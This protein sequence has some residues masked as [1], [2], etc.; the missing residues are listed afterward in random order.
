MVIEQ[1]ILELIESSGGN[2]KY[3]ATGKPYFE[4]DD[5]VFLSLNEFAEYY[6]LNYYVFLRKLNKNISLQEIIAKAKNVKDHLGNSYP[7]TKAMCEHYGISSS[8]FTSRI[9]RNWDLQAA[10]ETKR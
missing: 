5:N 1:K 2:V 3:S 4:Y 7:S 6:K 10:L 8:L 9:K